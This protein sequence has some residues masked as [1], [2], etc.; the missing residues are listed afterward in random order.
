VV[1]LGRS[2]GKIGGEPVFSPTSNG[3]ISRVRR[4]ASGAGGDA[5]GRGPLGRGPVRRPV[6]AGGRRGR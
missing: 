2:E 4:N 5:H 1:V 6:P 3:H